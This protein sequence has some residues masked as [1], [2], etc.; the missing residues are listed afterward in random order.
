MNARSVIG[1]VLTLA[2]LAGQAFVPLTRAACGMPRGDAPPACSFCAGAR[3]PGALD[4]ASLVADRS[5]CAAQKP[6]AERDPA[7]VSASRGHESR[8]ETVAVVAPACVSTA[9]PIVTG[10]NLRE[11]PPPLFDSPH[12]RTTVFLI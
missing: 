5:C 10:T 12:R 8:A 3:A 7:T 1:S 9:I 11:S 4:G 2:L 6:P